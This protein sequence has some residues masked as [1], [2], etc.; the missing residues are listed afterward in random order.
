MKRALLEAKHAV[1]GKDG[2][3]V[4]T[5]ED[6][7]LIA[8]AE[9]DYREWKLAVFFN[10]GPQAVVS[11]FGILRDFNTKVNAMFVKHRHLVGFMLLRR[12]Q[13]CAREGVPFSIPPE[14]GYLMKRHLKISAE[15]FSN[16]RLDS[17]KGPAI[18][19]HDWFYPEVKD[20]FRKVR[21]HFTGLLKRAG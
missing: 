3:P 12:A 18:Q 16:R 4:M 8:A 19:V 2:D 6:D 21:E 17:F 10:K 1:G 7:Q 5:I 15:E 20:L 13:Q 11:R 9:Q 14:L